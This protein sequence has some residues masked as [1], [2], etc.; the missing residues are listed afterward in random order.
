VTASEE[1]RYF[2]GFSPVETFSQGDGT[3]LIGGLTAGPHHIT[4]SAPGYTMAQG[5]AAAGADDVELLLD[6]AGTVTGMV[7]EEG[8][9]AVEGFRVQV[10]HVGGN[11]RSQGR[12][13]RSKTV[14]SPDGR[15]VLEDLAPGGYVL[16]VIVP[17]RAPAVL[18]GVKVGEAQTTDVGA[19]RVPRGG[20]VRGLA[21]DGDGG[22]V[23]GA[24]VTVSTGEMDMLTWMGLLSDQ[25]SAQGAFEVRGVP[26]GAA[27]V[28]ATH[29]SYAPGSATVDV[30]PS[31][32][33]AEARIILRQGGLVEGVARRRDGQPLP[34]QTIWVG[35]ADQR[36]LE[37][38]FPT[39]SADGSFR[40]EH[41][42]PG[43][44]TVALM[45]SAGPGQFVNAVSREID[46]L[47]G[48]TTSV[49]LVSRDVHVAGRVTRNRT[50][51]A[52]VGLELQNVTGFSMAL[53]GGFG[54]SAAPSDGP[55]RNEAITREDGSFEMIVSEP[56]RYHVTAQ[57]AIP[58]MSLPA[59]TIEIP[60]VESHTLELDFSGVPVA[61]VVVDRETETPI[62]RAHVAVQRL[63]AREVPDD[64]GWSSGTSG[65]DGRFEFMAAPGQSRLSAGAEGRARLQNELTLGESGVS[66]LRIEL[67]PG[68]EI[69]GRVVNAAG[70]G[71][72]GVQVTGIGTRAKE[73]SRGG[74]RTRGDG[75][76]T[77]ANLLDVPHSVAAGSDIAGFAVRSAVKPGAHDV[78]LTLQP[79]GRARLLVLDAQGAPVSGAYPMVSRLNGAE[80]AV[81]AGGGRSTDG[82]GRTE[83]LVPAG[84]L[85]LTAWQPKASGRASVTVNTGE[86]VDVELRLTDP[87]DRP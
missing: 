18:S 41:V 38:P 29:P 35:F 43:R 86:T 2:S 56:G 65:P 7:I 50:P 23:A 44:A 51:A 19:I 71:L 14:A 39:T 73:R 77:L 34:G 63:N 8:D 16:R 26:A 66:D 54:S 64:E 52:G 55:R 6:I 21:V 67:S 46:V 48:Q 22:A 17:E 15:F 60:D 28:R 78:T 84:A 61:G 9:R 49:E 75:S 76:F 20:I 47:E 30:D 33:P 79:G 80:V 13:E 32:G 85:E 5:Q 70:Q 57:T 36:G 12:R 74:A 53:A 81:P 59:R 69:T 3:F 62:E 25:S 11:Q 24:R 4:A 42:P 72:A 87:P 40:L 58:R 31:K 45:A 10:Q 82:S 27:R 68:F 37:T 83:M 1:Q